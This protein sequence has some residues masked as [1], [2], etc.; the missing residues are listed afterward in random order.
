MDRKVCILVGT[1]RGAHEQFLSLLAAVGFVVGSAASAMPAAPIRS[2]QFAD[3]IQVGYGCGL[4]VRRG[5]FGT[6]RP[7]YLYEVYDPYY[8]GYV[9][10]YYDGYRDGAYPYLRY[11][12]AGDV[13]VVDRGVC[14]FGSYLLCNAG[15]C[16]RFCY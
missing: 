15:T 7:V 9:R 16:W 12:G 5:P 14:G 4:G 6:C 11:Y 13:M 3:T 8:G 2:G 10:G 1:V